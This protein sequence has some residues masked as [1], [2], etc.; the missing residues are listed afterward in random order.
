[1][2]D[3]GGQTQGPLFDTKELVQRIAAKRRSRDLTLRDVAEETGVSVPTLSRVLRGHMPD[4][5][6]LLRLA[7][8]VGMRIDPVPGRRERNR[9]V[10]PAHVSTVEAVELHLRADRDLRGEDAEALAELFKI[11]YDRLRLHRDDEP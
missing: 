9:R 3:P 5:E 4:R 11:A 1:M 8:W 7:R 6:N 10:H 2:I